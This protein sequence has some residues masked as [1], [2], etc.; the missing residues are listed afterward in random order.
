MIAS[1]LDMGD[2]TRRL[3]AGVVPVALAGQ[4]ADHGEVAWESLFAPDIG[5]A[6]W[7]LLTFLTLLYILGRFAWKPLLGALDA[8]EKRIQG[9]IDEARQQREEAET[10]LARQ[11]EQLAE[12]RV[13]AQT[14]IGEAR[15]AA[16]AVRRELEEKAREESRQMLENARREIERERQAA[17][18]SVRRESVDVALAVASRLLG[19]Q[20]DAARDRRL[21]MSYIDDLAENGLSSDSDG[22]AADPDATGARA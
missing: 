18:A 15:T 17:V 5:L 3:A 4:E 14:M 20:M 7:T 12:V 6:I 21:A 10:L 11:K 1:K 9:N 16:E 13:Q 2:P 22:R 8:R 19:E